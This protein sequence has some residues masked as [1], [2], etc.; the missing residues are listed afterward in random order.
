MQVQISLYYLIM[1][2]RCKHQHLA[3]SAVRQLNHLAPISLCTNSI[4]AYPLL[5]V[6]AFFLRLKATKS[7]MPVTSNTIGSIMLSSPPVTGISAVGGVGT[8]EPG[9]PG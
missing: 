3:A 7:A 9:Q 6:Y 4:L 5:L 8:F 1:R 2:I